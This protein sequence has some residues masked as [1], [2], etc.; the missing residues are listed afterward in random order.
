MTMFFVIGNEFA[1]GEL[2]ILCELLDILDEK[3]VEIDQLIRKSEGPESDGLLD[4]GEYFI[5][6]GFVAIQRYL[7]E[8]ILFTGLE[9]REAYSLGPAHSSGE[10]YIDL[11]NYCANWWKHEPEWYN[12]KIVPKNGEKS[13]INITNIADT[14]SYELSNVLASLCG[15][16]KFC[17]DSIVPYLKEWR[18]DV[19][20]SR[21][22]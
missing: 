4:R 19:H 22:K 6:V 1:D 14:P 16:S 21:K 5:G 13:F 10:T 3:L 7:V 17:F 20:K 8:T 9:K 12:N 15:S 11:M 18:A 2:G